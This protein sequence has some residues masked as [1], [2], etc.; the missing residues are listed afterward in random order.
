MHP[1]F[2]GLETEVQPHF[3]EVVTAQV[4]LSFIPQ[5]W[6]YFTAA[7][8]CRTKL[9]IYHVHLGA[10]QHDKFSVYYQE[11]TELTMSYLVQNIKGQVPWT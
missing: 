8:I 11:I 7:L 4:M 1:K 2:S 3:M 5:A 10:Y 9:K 6:L